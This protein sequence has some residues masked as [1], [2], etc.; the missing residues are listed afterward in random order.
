MM[1]IYYPFFYTSVLVFFFDISTCLKMKRRRPP[2]LRNEIYVPSL[3]DFELKGKSLAW[4]PVQIKN[5]D[6]KSVGKLRWK[7]HRK[8]RYVEEADCLK[9][10]KP[11]RIY[12]AQEDQDDPDA[13]DSE[14]GDD[15]GDIAYDDYDYYDDDD[16]NSTSNADSAEY[17]T[18]ATSLKEMNTTDTVADESS[19]VDDQDDLTPIVE[20]NLPPKTTECPLT[21]DIQEPT[22]RKVPKGRGHCRNRYH[23]YQNQMLDS[24]TEIENTKSNVGTDSSEYS[25]DTGSLTNG[26]SLETTSNRSRTITKLKYYTDDY[27]DEEVSI[28]KSTID[29]VVL[30]TAETPKVEPATNSP[31]IY[32]DSTTKKYSSTVIP[33]TSSL[34]IYE[35]STINGHSSL[36]VTASKS[37]EQPEIYEESTIKKSISVTVGPVTSSTEIYETSTTEEAHSSLGMTAS[38]SDERPE[39]YHSETI[40]DR[41]DMLSS[42]KDSNTFPNSGSVP[43]QQKTVFTAATLSTV[44]QNT[45]SKMNNFTNDQTKSGTNATECEDDFNYEGVTYDICKNTRKG[46]LYDERTTETR[47]RHI[48][49]PPYPK[50]PLDLRFPTCS[51][52]EDQLDDIL[53]PTYVPG[54][55]ND[56][57]NGKKFDDDSVSDSGKDSGKSSTNDSG[58]SFEK[59]KE[60]SRKNRK[61]CRR[62]STHLTT[63]IISSKA[64]TSSTTAHYVVNQLAGNKKDAKVVV[65]IPPSLSDIPVVVVRDPLTRKLS[66]SLIGAEQDS[67]QPNPIYYKPSLYRQM[68]PP[69]FSYNN[70]YSPNILPFNKLYPY[71]YMYGPNVGYRYDKPN[72]VCPKRL[73]FY[74]NYRWVRDTYEDDDEDDEEDD[75]NSTDSEWEIYLTV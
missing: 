52:N 67:I 42:S 1:N 51:G 14:G 21:D 19:Y 55:K 54:K 6:I 66:L 50:L 36:E 8:C 74:N 2:E 34:E 16:D 46:Y 10:G 31:E 11:K 22:E 28:T 15:D 64:L 18:S 7:K 37:D 56:K 63:Q 45:K 20:D 17:E 9:T 38:K 12:N 29:Q 3:I 30:T 13:G 27:D 70:L 35:Q 69:P 47:L 5:H 68:F 57:N 72:Y 4:F 33:V 65:R 71:D 44:E 73:R 59:K 39:T 25:M 32:E 40:P 48:E 24:T 75:K 41:L 58:K 60:K 61:H 53:S 26:Q 43:N 49:T 23:T 62:K